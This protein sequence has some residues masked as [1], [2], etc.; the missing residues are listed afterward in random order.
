MV[1]LVVGSTITFLRCRVTINA[2]A[3]PS[4]CDTRLAY[5]H[6]IVVLI[7]FFF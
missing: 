4:I 6:I 7:F 3:G 1:L 5:L 2:G